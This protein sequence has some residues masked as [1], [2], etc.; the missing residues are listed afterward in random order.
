MLL[1]LTNTCFYFAFRNNSKLECTEFVFIIFVA[2]AVV[3]KYFYVPTLCIEAERREPG[4]QKRIPSDEGDADNLF[5]HGQALYIMCEL[6]GRIFFYFI[7][8]IRMSKNSMTNVCESM[9]HKHLKDTL[10]VYLTNSQSSGF[11]LT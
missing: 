4:S 9:I 2:D 7:V 5:L 8:Q 10:D 6:L 1:N 3:P 11:F